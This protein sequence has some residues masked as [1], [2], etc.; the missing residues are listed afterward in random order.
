MILCFLGWHRWSR[1]KVFAM[2]IQEREGDHLDKWDEDWQRR[3]CERC[4]LTQ[5]KECEV[6]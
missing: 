1:W 2:T 5:E 3:F 6:R 4:G